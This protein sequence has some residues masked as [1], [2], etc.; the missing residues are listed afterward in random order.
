M[1]EAAV[2]QEVQLTLQLSSP[3]VELEAAERVTAVAGSIGMSADKIDEVRGYADRAPL[4][5]NNPLDPAN[6]RVTILVPFVE[7][8]DASDQIGAG[9]LVEVPTGN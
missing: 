5:R 3:D 1:P 6:R 2:L 4:F 9:D 7:I 8:F